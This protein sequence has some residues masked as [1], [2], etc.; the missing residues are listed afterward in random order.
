MLSAEVFSPVYVAE[1]AEKGGSIYA[2]QCAS[3]HGSNLDNGQFAQPLKGEEFL[4]R[5]GGKSAD[6]LFNHISR[7]MPPLAPGS[8]SDEQVT[9]LLAF[10]LQNNNVQPGDK[11]LSAQID[12]LKLVV[13]PSPTHFYGG[14][15]A[16]V[17]LPLPPE[18]IA[19]PLDHITPVTEQMLQ[20][21]PKGEWLTWRRTQ[22]A[23]GFSPLK[24]IN[25]RNIQRLNVAWTWSLPNGPNE[26]TPLVHDGVMFIYGH[27]DVVQALNAVTGDFL[28]QYSHRLPKDRQPSYKKAMALYGNKLYVATSDVHIVALDV[29]TGDVVW[30]SPV[31]PEGMSFNMTGGPLV[32]KGNVIV[33]TV[34]YH[35]KPAGGGNFIVALNAETGKLVWRFATI[36]RPGEPGGN[37]WNGLP[38][39]QRLGGSVWTP[40]SYDPQLG[41]VFFGPAPTYDTA[42]LRDLVMDGKSTNDALFTNTT[43]ALNPSTGKRVW[44]FQHLPNDQWDMDWAFERQIINLPV[45]GKT[46][47]VVITSGK[48]AIYDAIEADTGAYLFSIDLG[49]QNLITAIDPKT[50]KKTIDPGKIPGDGKVKFICPHV[51]GGKNWLPS[52]YNPNTKTLFVTLAESCMN[53]NPVAEGEQGLLSTGVRPGLR[54]RTDS[55]G[56]YG[57]LQ[58]VN[59]VS[60]KTIWMARQRAPITTGALATA[61]GLV[62]IGAMDRFFFRP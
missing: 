9:H 10:I 48:P 24:Q 37:S 27:G 20:D 4:L 46:K 33:G 31:G 43:L 39:D 14:L 42:P 32:A 1:Q 7:A 41:L 62:F 17:A 3:R 53:M 45:N 26:S 18:V 58:A 30:D 52:S 28:W 29:K 55:D 22:D 19:N 61:G 56:R 38:F 23:E 2:Q 60:R 13:L 50:G 21:P 34:T 49:L 51:E 11:A 15:A 16:D 25:K 47:R 6:R 54:P 40:G 8:L 35:E 36:A 44:H 12:M 59:L 5:W 57:R